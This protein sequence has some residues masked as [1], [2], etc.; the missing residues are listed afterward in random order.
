[1]V[2]VEDAEP[3]RPDIMGYVL[4]LLFGM[5]F[6]AAAN[7]SDVLL[8]GYFNWAKDTGIYAASLLT[9]AILAVII[10]SLESFLAPLL[11]ESLALGISRQTL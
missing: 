6:S 3:T 1:M 5:L 8:L 7:R 11:S 10:Q 2:P 4:P 9:S